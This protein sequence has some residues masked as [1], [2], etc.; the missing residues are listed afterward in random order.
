MADIKVYTGSLAFFRDIAGFSPGDIDWIV[1]RDN[2][3]GM[4]IARH[5]SLEGVSVFEWRY[6]PADELI[7]YVLDHPHPPMQVVM[8]LIPEVAAHIGMTVDLLPRLK[9]LVDTLDPRH[10]YARII[11]ESYIENGSFT[12]TDEQRTAAYRNYCEARR[13]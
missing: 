11:Y 8:F 4:R 5:R 9:P 6:M 3:H 7:N 13:H 2:P 10:L 1:I 12:L